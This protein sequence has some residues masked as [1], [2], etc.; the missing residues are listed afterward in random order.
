[1]LRRCP[2]A[3]FSPKQLYHIELYIICASVCIGL[4]LLRKHSLS[5]SSFVEDWLAYSTTKL[6][7]AAPTIES[8]TNFD[9]DILGKDKAIKTSKIELD[10]SPIMYNSTTLR[11]L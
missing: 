7:G 5:P 8:I 1:M 10:D 11:Q 3:A 4:D 2:L 9:K 6:S